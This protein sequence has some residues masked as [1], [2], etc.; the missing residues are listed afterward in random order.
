MVII[1]IVGKPTSGKE[2]LASILSKT[3]GFKIVKLPFFEY[4]QETESNTIIPGN[5]AFEICKKQLMDWTTNQVIF[6]IYTMEQVKFMRFFK[7]Y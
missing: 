7:C 2:E 3:W 6:P 1:G 4:T 5:E